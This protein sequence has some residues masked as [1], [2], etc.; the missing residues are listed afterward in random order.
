MA[1]EP[2]KGLGSPRATDGVHAT[3][4][5]NPERT[6]Q[7]NHTGGITAVSSNG[8]KEIFS[9]NGAKGVKL[10]IEGFAPD[11]DISITSCVPCEHTILF[12]S[13]VH[14]NDEMMSLFGNKERASGS[15]RGH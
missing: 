6:A 12:T 8:E 10:L 7:A 14:S 4:W 3:E 13:C 9:I 1:R 5:D 15:S 11:R 2:R